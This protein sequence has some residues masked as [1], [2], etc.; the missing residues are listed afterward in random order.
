LGL[1]FASASNADDP[2]LVGWWKFD[3]T[4]G[5][6]AADS[7]GQ[8]YNGTLYG[9]PT[10]QPTGGKFG[11]ALQFDGVND[12]VSLPIGSVISS[13]SDCTIAL[14][15]NW[16]GTGS[17]NQRIFEFASG[18]TSYMYLTPN[19]QTNGALRFGIS[20]GFAA[21]ESQ[22]TA[23]FP[24]PSGWHHVAVV[25]DGTTKNMQLYLDGEVVAT[26]ITSVLPKDLGPTT[27]NFLGKSLNPDPL[28]DPYFFM[29]YLDELVMATRMFSKLDIEELLHEPHP[30]FPPVVYFTYQGRLL[31]GDSA[32]NGLYDFQFKLYDSNT[33]GT[34]VAFIYP[35]D[36]VNVIDGYFT[37]KL[38]FHD[39]P[40][41]F[42]GDPRWLEISVRPGK[43][44]GSF[45]TLSPRQEITPTPY[46][47]FAKNGGGWIITSDDNTYSSVSGNVGIGTES[48]TAKL[49]VNGDLKVTGAYKGNIGP[50][51]GAPFPRPAYD[52]G[53]VSINAGE[54]IMLTHNIGGN[55]DNY[56]VDM[57][58]KTHAGSIHNFAFGSDTDGDDY[59]GFF[60]LNLTNSCVK[61]CRGYSDIECPYVRV[62]IWVYN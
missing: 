9:G 26:G 55:V 19:S 2:N 58:A 62:R 36:D 47:F 22:L 1:A 51:N 38:R 20:N 60:Y 44:T 31:D 56:V 30:Q 39:Y 42:N 40:D 33:L 8:G 16:S 50:N 46:A 32:V 10:W 5:T 7:S 49:E 6:T 17:A 18:T 14:W 24:L 11:G 48:P 53:W 43:S 35:V 34:E 21:P 28:L 25:I 13:L 61:I 23:P 41:V 54:Q 4:S 37:V 59:W 15:A 29:G 27:Q 3:E 52:S 45:T 57:Q 12:Y